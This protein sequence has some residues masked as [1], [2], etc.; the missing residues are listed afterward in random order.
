M[1]KIDNQH[2]ELQSTLYSHLNGKRIWKKKIFF[3]LD[4]TERL[5]TVPQ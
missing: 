2:M 5:S 3:K 4:I 1:F